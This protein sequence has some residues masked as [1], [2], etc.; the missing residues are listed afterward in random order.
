MNRLGVILV[1]ALVVGSGAALGTGEPL[2]TVAFDDN[3][4]G[5]F[6]P[7]TLAAYGDD[8]DERVVPG[9][10]VFTGHPAYVMES[11]DARLVF[12]RPRIHYFA[13]TFRGTSHGD[14]QY[15]R[16]AAALSNGSAP[17]AI[18]NEMTTLMLQ[19]DGAAPA[20]QAFE[21]HYCAVDEPETQ[22]LYNRT[23]ATLY[24]YQPDCPADRRPQIAR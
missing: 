10:R 12:D 5:W 21:E 17:Y 4:D 19:W 9:E 6:T 8:L 3:P 11:D 24:R 14:R 18:G 22:R 15:R 20:R 7:A 13:V 16:L 1:V 23:G 2:A